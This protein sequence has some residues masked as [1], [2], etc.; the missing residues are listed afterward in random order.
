MPEKNE[1]IDIQSCV[2]FPGEK[3]RL[4]VKQRSVELK[5][6]HKKN[7]KNLVCDRFLAVITKGL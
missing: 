4:F 6:F 7:Y 5:V 3:Q 2:I 1:W